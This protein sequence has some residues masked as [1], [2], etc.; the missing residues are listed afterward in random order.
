MK[1]EYVVVNENNSILG[2]IGSR[3][4]VSVGL[5]MF[6]HLLQYKLSGPREEGDKN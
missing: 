4:K 3:S 6:S 1:F 5:Q 2:I